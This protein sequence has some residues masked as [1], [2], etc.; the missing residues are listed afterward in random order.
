MCLLDEVDNLLRHEETL[1]MLKVSQGDPRVVSHGSQQSIRNEQYKAEG[2][3]RYR[4]TSH[5]RV[6]R[7]TTNCAQS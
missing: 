3:R 1:N 6:S 2:S 7:S 4:D 5:P